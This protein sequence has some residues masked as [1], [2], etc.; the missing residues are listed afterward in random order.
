MYGAITLA[1]I[2]LII[3]IPWWVGVGVVISRAQVIS[4]II[5]VEIVFCTSTN[6]L[7][8]LQK[9]YPTV[10]LR[11]PYLAKI[12]FTDYENKIKLKIL[13]ELGKF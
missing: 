5:L 4:Y 6:T 12:P 2:A 8:E 13:H 10:V 7:L 1:I 11:I 3:A 9:A